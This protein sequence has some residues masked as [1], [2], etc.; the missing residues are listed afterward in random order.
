MLLHMMR[1][2]RTAEREEVEQILTLPQPSRDGGR[3]SRRQGIHAT[4]KQ[5]VADGE[6]TPKG[7]KRLQ[8]SNLGDLQ[9]RSKTRAHVSRL[10]DLINKYGSIDYAAAI[11]QR[12]ASDARAVFETK[13][14]PCMPRSVHRDVL[15]AVVEYV[16]R[17][18]R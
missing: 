18:H 12:W 2:A 13:V 10:F 11:A 5:M 1:S 3:R 9:T 6:L 17:R 16:H 15:E 14:V 8:Q 4:L 7:Y